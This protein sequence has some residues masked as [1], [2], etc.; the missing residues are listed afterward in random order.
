[1]RCLADFQD[2]TGSK[3]LESCT[4]VEAQFRGVD[5]DEPVT[6]TIHENDGHRL[7]GSFS[8][9]FFDGSTLEADIVARGLEAV[10][11]PQLPGCD[12]R[13]IGACTQLRDPEKTAEFEKTCNVDNNND[14][15]FLPDGCPS[16]GASCSGTN[17][18]DIFTGD[19]YD[20]TVYIDEC[21]DLG[22]YVS[23]QLCA[24]I[25]GSDPCR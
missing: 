24:M 17:P 18:P 13:S 6:F 14:T 20:V 10:E 8:V 21:N 2:S 9:S 15:A 23:A 19:S 3:D 11:P 25:G 16:T 12:D 22:A 5:W 4:Q 7:E 1:L